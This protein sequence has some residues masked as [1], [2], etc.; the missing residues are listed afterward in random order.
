MPRASISRPAEVIP[1]QGNQDELVLFMNEGSLQLL[2]NS[3]LF[4]SFEPISEN[5]WH[6]VALQIDGIQQRLTVFIDG[7]EAIST[8]IALSSNDNDLYIGAY[9]AETGGYEGLIDD[10]LIFDRPLDPWEIDF[11]AFNTL[12]VN[13]SG[14]DLAKDTDGDGLKDGLE[15][16]AYHTDPTKADS[17]GDGVNDGDEIEQ[18]TDPNQSDRVVS[19]EPATHP[20]TVFAEGFPMALSSITMD[21]HTGDVYVVDQNK[22]PSLCLIRRSGELIELASNFL[23]PVNGTFPYFATDI[24]YFEGKLYTITAQGDLISFD[25]NTRTA[26]IVSNLPGV[27]GESGLDWITQGPLP[28]RMGHQH[29]MQ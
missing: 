9:N 28:S 14:F 18:G 20:L 24:E 6:H 27:A 7:R 13:S 8:R 23:G 16:N 25:I 26:S 2:A 10:V 21:R 11:L 5:E 4:Q 1:G 12:P 15:L 22:L 29:Q 17:D 3:E 19:Q